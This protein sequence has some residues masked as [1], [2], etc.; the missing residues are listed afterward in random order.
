METFSTALILGMLVSGLILVSRMRLSSMIQLFRVESVLLTIFALLH[1]VKSVQGELFAVAVL[2]FALKVLIIPWFLLKVGRTDADSQRLQAYIRPTPVT[3]LAL[4]ATVAAGFAAHALV[5]FGSAMLVATASFS[6]VAFGL[7]LL[8]VR[9]DMYGQGIGFLTM[10]NG[11]YI[12]GLALT[13]GMPFFIEIG[14]LFDL[15]ILFVLFVA[16]LRRA[17][18]EHASAGTEHLQEL[19]D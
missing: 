19:I 14:V 3:F 15:M 6:V 9:R 13:G 16:L 12:F 5:G 17:H 4:I 18:V 11:I 8:M 1:A 7:L 10:E 2:I